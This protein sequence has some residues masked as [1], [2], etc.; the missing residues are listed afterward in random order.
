MQQHEQ[1]PVDT[2]NLITTSDGFLAD[3]TPFFKLVYDFASSTEGDDLS[4]FEQFGK[5]V[6]EVDNI[7]WEHFQTDNRNTEAFHRAFD[8]FRKFS[9]FL[10]NVRFYKEGG[11]K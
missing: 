10:N 6:K 4:V 3:L 1:T 7:F 2:G 11:V 5:D 9:K 8:F